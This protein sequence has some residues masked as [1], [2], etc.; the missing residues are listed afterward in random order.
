MNSDD[1]VVLTSLG[2]VVII[3]AG[4]LMT[5]AFYIPVVV[6]FLLILALSKLLVPVRRKYDDT[7]AFWLAFSILIFAIVIFYA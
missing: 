3:L 1:V 4:L 5:A 6:G 7:T 2:T